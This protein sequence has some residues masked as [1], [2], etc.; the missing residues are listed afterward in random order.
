VNDVLPWG[1][2]EYDEILCFPL[3]LFVAVEA[4]VPVDFA[5]QR[6]ARLSGGKRALGRRSVYRVRALDAL[7][8]GGSLQDGIAVRVAL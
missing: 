3:V 5:R 7:V 8:F 4:I 1:E 6:H 2:G